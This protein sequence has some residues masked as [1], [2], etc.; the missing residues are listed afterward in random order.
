MALDGSAI[1]YQ[2]YSGGF[3]NLYDES[4]GKQCN[5]IYIYTQDNSG[6]SSATASATAAVSQI[7]DGQPQAPTSQASAPVVS[8]IS[9]GQP[10][11]PSSQASAPVVSQI[12]DG[13]PQAPTSQAAVPSAPL[14]SQITDGQSLPVY[15]IRNN[16]KH[17]SGQPQAPTQQ[18]STPQATVVG[19]PVTQISDGQV[20]APTGAPSV[21]APSAPLVTQISDGQP[22]APVATGGN[23]TSPN[24]TSPVQFPGAATTPKAAVGAFA[25]GLLAMMFML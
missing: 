13:Q 24:A 20:Q 14:V 6:S 17:F 1:W 22:Q 7:T 3:Y 21:S 10:Q 9:D 4:Q 15:R 8:Q 23:Y 16:T 25:A 18:A 5:K 19:P 12:S 11:A 2:C